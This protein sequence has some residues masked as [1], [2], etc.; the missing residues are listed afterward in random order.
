MPDLPPKLF[1][2]GTDTDVGKTVISALICAAYQRP[3]F[4]PVQAGVLPCTDSDT[5][6]RLAQA[7]TFPERHRLGR[8]ASPH[9]SAHDEGVRILR[10][11]FQLPDTETLVVEGAGGVAVPLCDSPELWQVQLMTHFALPALIVARSGLGT[12]NHTLLTTHYLRHHGVQ[13]AGIVLVGAAHPENRR[14]LGRWGAPVLARV[15]RVDNLT[16]QFPSL[17]A[18]FQSQILGSA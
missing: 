18:D 1:V 16:E 8:P 17:V 11:D 12:L 3:Y 14:D 9:A 2:T 7:R 13:I 15:P 4:K 10:A 5:V 6:R